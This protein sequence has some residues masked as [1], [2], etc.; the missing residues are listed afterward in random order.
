MR[1]LAIWVFALFTIGCEESEEIIHSDKEQPEEDQFEKGFVYVLQV[2]VHVLHNGEPIGEGANLA[3]DRIHRQIEILNEDF[4]RKIDTP[5]Y[6]DHPDG[7]DAR[8]EFVLANESPEGLETNGINRIDTSQFDIPVGYGIPH[9]AQYD[10][11]PSDQY[12]N[13]W[14]V[15]LDESAKCWVLGEA[16][17]PKTDLPGTE[18]LALPAPGEPEGILINWHHFGESDIECNSKG[19]TLTHE[20]GHYLGLLHTWGGKSCEF[21][22]YCSDTPAVDYPVTSNNPQ[23]GCQGEKVM[24][25]NYMNWTSD[26]VMNIFTKD[27]VNRMHYVLENHPGRNA[28][29]LKMKK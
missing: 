3:S 6:N 7:A 20:M 2:V 28:L 24:V 19:R 29:I 1:L 22:D 18:H 21:N 13:I 25:E 8:I 10:Y 26:E 23:V 17:G 16:T 27:Q 4:R 12:I 5:G 14:T 15:P 11:W 9:F